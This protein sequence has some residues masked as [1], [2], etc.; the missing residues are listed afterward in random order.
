MDN[1]SNKKYLLLTKKMDR[2]IEE[3]LDEL[4]NKTIQL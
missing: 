2:R 4:V 3:A 1:V